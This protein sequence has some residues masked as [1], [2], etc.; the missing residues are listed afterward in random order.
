MSKAEIST[1]A[2][3]HGWRHHGDVNNWGKFSKENMRIVATK[4]GWNV[5]IFCNKTNMF[6]APKLYENFEEALSG[7][8]ILMQG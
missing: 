2:K 4:I 6:G 5:Q 8:E 3:L 7:A 1:L